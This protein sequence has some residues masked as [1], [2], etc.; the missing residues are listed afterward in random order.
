MCCHEN[1][2]QL[3]RLPRER[4]CQT[5]HHILHVSWKP[6]YGFSLILLYNCNIR[7]EKKKQF[8]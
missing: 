5:G 6:T 4:H 7:K 2:H 1:Q 8:T 3:T